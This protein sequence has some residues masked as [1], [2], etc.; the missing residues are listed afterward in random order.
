M[1]KADV[2]KAW[3]PELRALGFVYRGKIFQFAETLEQS[4]Q[5]N[6]FM[7]RNIYEDSYQT[8][9]E[10]L[11]RSP[12]ISASKLEVL[13][14]AN[15]QPMGIQFHARNETWWPPARLPDALA[16]LMRHV[17]PWFQVWGSPEFLVERFE[18]TI[19]QHKPLIK[20]IEPLSPEEEELLQRGWPRTGEWRVPA[21]I[22]HYASILHYL[23]GNKEMSIRRTE[24]WLSRLRPDEQAERSEAKTQLAALRGE[25]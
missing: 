16:G 2:V 22:F 12:L 10:V 11:I 1:T 24:D 15:L 21:M 14:S 6:I 20:V 5:L 9:P 13:L 19:E 4:L 23:V 17:L 3:K 8:G 7:Q 25:V 18:M